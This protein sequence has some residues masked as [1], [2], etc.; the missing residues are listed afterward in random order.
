MAN[1]VYA[2]INKYGSDQY[3]EFSGM[4]QDEVSAMLTAQGLTFEIIGQAT[5]QENAD[6]PVS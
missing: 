6:K 1:E 4:T 5:F 3:A 2:K